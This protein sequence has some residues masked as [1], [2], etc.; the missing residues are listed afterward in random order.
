MLFKTDIHPWIQYL[1]VIL[2]MLLG[3]QI[4]IGDRSAE[5]LLIVYFESLASLVELFYPTLT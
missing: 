2:L 4:I 3:N 1:I 5:A